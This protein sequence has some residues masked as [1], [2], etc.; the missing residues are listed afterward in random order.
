MIF[1]DPPP[2]ESLLATLTA[3]E[4]EVHALASARIDYL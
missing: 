3:L 4:H 2:F 1:G